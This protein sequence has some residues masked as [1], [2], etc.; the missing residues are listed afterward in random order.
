MHP[1]EIPDYSVNSVQNR[2]NRKR[3][4]IDNVLN[5]MHEIQMQMIEDALSQSD[6]R[7]TK[8]LIQHFLEKK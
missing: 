8:E 7:Q 3:Q 5:H 2:A 6:M 4:I 1:D